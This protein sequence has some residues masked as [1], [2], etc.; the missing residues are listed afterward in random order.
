MRG[1]KDSSTWNSSDD[2]VLS[3]LEENWPG[4]HLSARRFVRGRPTLNQPSSRNAARAEFF[5]CMARA[6]MAPDS[7]AMH[8]AFTKYLADDL[9]ELTHQIEYRA[10]R[11]IEDLRAAMHEAPDQLALLQLYS[12]LFLTPPALVSIN[13]GRYSDGAVRGGSELAMEELYRRYGLARAEGFHDLYDHVSVQLE[14]VASLLFRAA[15]ASDPS[16]ANALEDEAR[17]FLAGFVA[18]WLPRFCADLRKAVAEHGVGGLYLHL[19][20]ILET[21]VEFEIGLLIEEHGVDPGTRPRKLA[22]VSAGGPAPEQLR[23]I[24]AVLEAHG[25]STDHLRIPLQSRDDA[26]GLERVTAIAP[27]DTAREGNCEG[28]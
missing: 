24:A 26:I 20:R 3:T 12:R 23:R 4:G 1:E 11:A 22:P 28:H 2:Q 14:F 5:L 16:E 25:L 7:T 15:E 10:L 6:F 13:T 17:R 8:E 27:E 19:A 9:A 21:A 18:R